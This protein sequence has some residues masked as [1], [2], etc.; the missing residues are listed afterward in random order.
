MEISSDEETTPTNV[1]L[2]AEVYSEEEYQRVLKRHK[3]RRRM[4]KVNK[5]C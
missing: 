1:K 3:K 2:S 4:K 5:Q